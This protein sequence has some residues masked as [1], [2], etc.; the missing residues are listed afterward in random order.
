M[1]NS[2]SPSRVSG[3]FLILMFCSFAGIVASVIY[4]GYLAIGL[5]VIAIALAVGTRSPEARRERR[6][7]FCVAGISVLLGVSAIGL[8]VFTRMLASVLQS[9]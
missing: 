5:G 1:D 6:V 7:V 2:Q 8:G 3:A 4:S 9:G